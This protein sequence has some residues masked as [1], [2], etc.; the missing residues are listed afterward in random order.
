MIYLV[1]AGCCLFLVSLVLA[2]LMVGVRYLRIPALVRLFPN[3][4]DLLRCHVDYILMS[5]VLF[6][7]G[8]LHPPI[9]M[10]LAACLIVGAT[11][12]PIL[13]LVMAVS[14]RVKALQPLWFKAASGVS[15]AIAT[16]G[17]GGTALVLLYASW[18]R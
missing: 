1:P 7:F 11:T 5:L 6:A 8:A 2:W 18:P 13:F 3:D 17:F 4:A 16:V 10:W 9:P 14:P 15:F 12:N